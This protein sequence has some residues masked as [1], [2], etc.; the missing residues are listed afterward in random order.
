MFD[1]DNEIYCSNYHSP[2]IQ[3]R[4]SA[5]NK[6]EK[7][8]FTPT[9]TGNQNHSHLFQKQKSLNLRSEKH[10]KTMKII[11]SFLHKFQSVGLNNN[12]EDDNSFDSTS[13]NPKSKPTS[14]T[15]F[16]KP[17]ITNKINLISYSNIQ[18]KKFSKKTIKEILDKIKN[19]NFNFENKISFPF[20]EKIGNKNGLKRIVFFEIDSV[21]LHSEY[22]DYLDYEKIIS[23]KLPS[24]LYAN[25]G[26]EIRPHFK[27]MINMIK[28]NYFICIYTSCENFYADSLI[29]VL[30]NNESIFLLKLYRNKCFKIN[31]NNHNVFFKDLRIIEGVDI[32]DIIIVDS[33]AINFGLNYR[34]GIPI[35]PYNKKNVN[36]EE[37]L[38]LGILLNN[39]YKKKDVGEF[40]ES[41]FESFF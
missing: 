36:D 20:P 39:M 17:I 16:I 10:V 11:P 29:E 28:E 40:I 18:K 26:V 23:I 13:K 21:L 38:N 3:I 4:K 1:S 27:E 31:V 6:T 15:D 7:L 5:K 2:S 37:L 34:N 14:F 41:T 12:N 19:F 35:S 22:D 25:I 33:S 8:L 9:T 24:G 32:N 30:D